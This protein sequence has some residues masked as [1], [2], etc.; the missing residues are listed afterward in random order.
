MWA[1]GA[2]SAVAE[3]P[4][5]LRDYLRDFPPTRSDQVFRDLLQY[6]YNNQAHNPTH[7]DDLYDVVFERIRSLS[8][9]HRHELLFREDSISAERQRTRP[10]VDQNLS[11]YAVFRLSMLDKDWESAYTR[12]NIPTHSP[13]TQLIWDKAQEELYS[14]GAIS[15]CAEFGL[16]D[17][18]L[19]VLQKL[20]DNHGGRSF[21]REQLDILFQIPPHSDKT[22]IGA[23]ISNRRLEC[24]D[25]LHTFVA[26]AGKRMFE[27]QN[28]VDTHHPQVPLVHWSLE[29]IRAGKGMGGEIGVLE[30]EED[31]LQRIINVEPRLLTQHDAEGLPPYALALKIEKNI[32]SDSSKQGYNGLSTVIRKAIYEQL[33]DPEDWRRALYAK[34]GT[35]NPC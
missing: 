20:I 23:A 6:I 28:V 15:A 7:A 35:F 12:P 4:G 26:G 18:L 33:K 32:R 16:N 22:A 30:K 5:A 25:T 31:L 2:Q 14:Q 9:S 34:S 19:A 17:L 27:V 11:V 21:S 24:F 29:Q 13:L 8:G 3:G 1:T 10:R